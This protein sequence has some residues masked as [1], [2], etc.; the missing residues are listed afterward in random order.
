[1][2]EVLPNQWLAHD[3][4]IDGVEVKGR[5]L[6][7]HL[8]R[9]FSIHHANWISHKFFNAEAARDWAQRLVVQI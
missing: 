7:V 4:V 8:H 9:A 5:K 3:W 6:I 1:M 2:R